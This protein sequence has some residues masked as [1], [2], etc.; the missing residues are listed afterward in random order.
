MTEMPEKGP[1][2]IADERA[3]QILERAAALDAEQSSE[4]SLPQLREAAVGAGISP[5]AFDQAMLEVGSEGD[6]SLTVP[7]R[8]ASPAHAFPNPDVARLARLLNDIQEEAGQLSV[9]GDR[10]EWK[11]GRGLQVSISPS[12]GELRRWCPAR[13]EWRGESGSCSRWRLRPPCSS[14]SGLWRAGKAPSSAGSSL[15]S[16]PSRRHAW[17]RRLPIGPR[18]SARPSE[19]SGCVIV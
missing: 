14:L 1:M 12:R 2:R 17:G 19:S 3:A 6:G 16:S 9:V 8:G 4:L 15:R 5:A 13:A 10:L 18:R 11:D 7:R